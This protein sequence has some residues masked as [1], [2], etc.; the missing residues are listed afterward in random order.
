MSEER[1]VSYGKGIKGIWRTF[2][3]E[4]TYIKPNKIYEYTYEVEKK[5]WYEFWRWFR[6]FDVTKFITK[7]K[8]NLAN[9]LGTKPENIELIYIYFDNKIGEIKIQWRWN[10][11]EVS[12]AFA[13][14]PAIALV[15]IIS[16]TIIFA[17]IWTTTHFRESK[18]LLIEFTKLAKYLMYTVI[19]GG[20]IYILT[21]MFQKLGEKKAKIEK[22]VESS[23]AKA[24]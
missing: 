8:D 5:E 1:P 14:I 6:S 21:K 19:G 15:S 24:K 13:W 10:E 3:P 20:S 7:F 17:T 23:Y 16:G 11:K 4:E 22:K 12:V 9:K 18:E 2:D